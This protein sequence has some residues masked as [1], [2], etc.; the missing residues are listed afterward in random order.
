[1]SDIGRFALVAPEEFVQHFFQHEGKEIAGLLNWVNVFK[2]DILTINQDLTPY[3]TIMTNVSSTESEYVSLIK[4][5][6]PDAR[7]LAC[8]DYGVSV[9][10]D[11]FVSLER[12]W[13][14]LSRSDILFS[15]A[16]LQS[17]W[18]RLALENRGYDLQVH[19]IPHPIDIENVMK[20]RR[21]REAR[22]P[23]SVAYHIHQY[24]H[25]QL[26]PLEV[27]KAVERKLQHPLR[28][29]IVGI[30]SRIWA[31]RGYQVPA[32]SW[33][34]ISSE[35][36]D[37]KLHGM[38]IDPELLCQGGQGCVL[39]P[40]RPHAPVIQQVPRG[41][42][43]DLAIPYLGVQGYYSYL[44]ENYVAYDAYT[45]DSIGRFTMDTSAVG[46]PCVGSNVT[47][48]AKLLYPFTTVNPMS[49]TDAV[50]ALVKLYKNEEWYSRVENT[51]MKNLKH[52]SFEESKRR[53]L[54]ALEM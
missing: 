4:Q 32:S 30:K 51:A 29:S 9:L 28:Q 17:E 41:V 1:M 21:P 37:P 44:A 6:N 26:L 5:E 52:Y 38:P 3:D 33:P 8:L 43:W 19:R 49:S 36:P 14:V 2:G 18:V 45:I 23:Y 50:N 24:D 47:D 16:K 15:V 22:V 54:N 10:D 13:Q 35:H 11:Y 27:L 34:I 12:V 48:S 20:Y 53:M 39:Q 46:V 7:I 40:Q 31:E 42:G 25:R